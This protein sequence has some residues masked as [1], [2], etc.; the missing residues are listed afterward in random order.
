MWW[1][2]SSPKSPALIGKDGIDQAVPAL[3]GKAPTPGI[4]TNLVTITKDN[5]SSMQRHVYKSSC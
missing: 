4:Q 5:L 3:E 2:R 1:T